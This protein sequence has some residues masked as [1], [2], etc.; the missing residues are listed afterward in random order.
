M[1]KERG[2]LCIKEIL[3]KFYGLN[4]KY[5]Y[6]LVE[7][8]GGMLVPLKGNHFVIDIA[9]YID[10]GVILVT[11]AGLGMIN[12]TLLNIEYAK[13]RDIKISGIIINNVLNEND[14]SLSSNKEILCEFTDVPII[15]DIPYISDKKLLND[16]DVLSGIVLNYIDLDK[17]LL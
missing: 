3:F 9:K 4:K 1:K 11:K 13:N 8:A 5:E 16:A 14:E 2:E 7:G 6:M 15:G 10:A 12:Q 17:I